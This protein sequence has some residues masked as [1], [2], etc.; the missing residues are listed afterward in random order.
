LWHPKTQ[1][2]LYLYT[3][4]VQPF[5]LGHEGKI[6]TY[7]SEAKTWASDFLA[8]HFQRLTKFL[9]SKAH[10]AISALQHVQQAQMDEAQGAG[11]KDRAATRDSK[12]TGA[13]ANLGGT[14]SK[15]SLKPR[16]PSGVDADVE[17]DDLDLPSVPTTKIL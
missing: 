8:A 14:R 6:D 9:Q 1:G 3:A 10:V 7:I 16:K 4:Y 15:K 13:K 17:E 2:A 12:A 11:R 5:L